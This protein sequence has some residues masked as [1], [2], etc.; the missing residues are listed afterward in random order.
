M[1]D[2]LGHEGGDDF[3][4][5]TSPEKADAVAG[6]IVSD[7][8]SGIRGFYSKEELKAGFIVEADRKG[9]V[10]RFPIMTISMAGVS[11]QFKAVS[12]YA[13]LTNVAVGVKKKAK[14]EA[15]SNFFLDRRKA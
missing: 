15:R 7:F 6:Q 11:N 2:F 1:G 3:F 5:I 13:E 4:F 8:D 9:E 10:V 14:S 12:G